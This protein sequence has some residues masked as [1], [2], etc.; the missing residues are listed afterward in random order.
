MRAI[1]MAVAAVQNLYL[2]PRTWIDVGCWKQM[3]MNSHTKSASV[4]ILRENKK[5]I[6]VFMGMVGIVG[7]D[8][9]N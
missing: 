1:R 2:Q 7:D 6:V 9:Y 4:V 8:A 5:I 3:K